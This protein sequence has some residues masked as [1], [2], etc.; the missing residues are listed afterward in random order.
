MPVQSDRLNESLER[1]RAYL[2]TLTFITV[3]PRLRG[4][5]GLSDVIQKTLME[6]CPSVELIE[7]MDVEEQKHW[8]R[9]MLLNNLKDEIDH[10][11]TKRRDVRRE[12]RPDAVAA[13]SSCRLADWLAAEDS[14]PSEKV[15]KEE[16]R[17]RVV[18]ALTQLP[19]RQR[20]ALILQQYHG[21]KLAQIA[22]RLK[23]TTGVVAGLHARGLAKLRELLADL[24]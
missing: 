19:E 3:D 24:E 14:T 6:A 5:F 18:D 21:W 11:L 9:R 20:E 16:R 4:K 1:Y 23:C 10:Y 12:Q 15:I 2:E 7:S 17:L 13:Q 22:E 8:L